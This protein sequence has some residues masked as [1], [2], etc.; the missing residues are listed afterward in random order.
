[1]TLSVQ[2]QVNRANSVTALSHVDMQ[3]ATSTATGCVNAFNPRAASQSVGFPT[4]AAMAQKAAALP[5][6]PAKLSIPVDEELKAAG[7]AARKQAVPQGTLRNRL[8]NPD[9]DERLQQDPLKLH[10]VT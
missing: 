1:M 7:R 4:G 6:V 2:V 10:K 9:L 8:D 5:S 3:L